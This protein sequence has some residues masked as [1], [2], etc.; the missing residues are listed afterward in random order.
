M[1]NCCHYSNDS[2]SRNRLTWLISHKQLISGTLALSAAP[3]TFSS[4]S[5]SRSKISAAS[6]VARSYVKRCLPSKATIQ[7]GASGLSRLMLFAISLGVYSF[8]SGLVTKSKPVSYP[9]VSKRQHQASCCDINYLQGAI[10]NS[11]G[12]ASEWPNYQGVLTAEL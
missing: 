11:R 5:I 8:L 10:M 6:P 1:F 2:V 9:T 3:F 12:A 7:V 4:G